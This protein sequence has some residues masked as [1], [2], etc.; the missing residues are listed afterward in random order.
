MAARSPAPS[1]QNFRRCAAEILRRM[2]TQKPGAASSN[3]T[4]FHPKSD[5]KFGAPAWGRSLDFDRG[6]RYNNHSFDELCQVI[7]ERGMGMKKIITRLVAV[8]LVAAL[9]LPVAAEWVPKERHQ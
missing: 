6:V 2:G 8:F 9:T 1:A 7:L 3:C 5:G 4:A